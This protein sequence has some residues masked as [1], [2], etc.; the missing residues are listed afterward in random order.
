MIATDC[1]SK[2]PFFGCWRGFY[3]VMSVALISNFFRIVGG[4]VLNVS[5]LFSTDIEK[6]SRY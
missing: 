6:Q 1:P 4:F 2:R 3:L 5:S